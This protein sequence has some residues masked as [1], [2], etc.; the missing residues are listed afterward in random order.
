MR[1]EFI[2]FVLTFK[3]GIY[4]SCAPGSHDV[5]F[6]PLLGDRSYLFSTFLVQTSFASLCA[7][8]SVLGL[9]AF[10]AVKTKMSRAMIMNARDRSFASIE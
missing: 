10:G 2:G 9:I 8:E 1:V 4:Q 5:W 6:R 3:L 7:V